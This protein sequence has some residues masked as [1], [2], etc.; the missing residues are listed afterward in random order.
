MLS[1]ASSSGLESLPPLANHDRPVPALSIRE[2]GRL[3]L[4]ITIQRMRTCEAAALPG[5]QAGQIDTL[6]CSI[7]QKLIN[8]LCPY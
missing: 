2:G 4:S 3:P 8:C 6:L 1:K 7:E 5:L